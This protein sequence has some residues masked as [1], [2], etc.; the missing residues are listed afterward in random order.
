[1]SEA[2]KIAYDWFERIIDPCDAQNSWYAEEPPIRR[3][4]VAATVKRQSSSCMLSQ[5]RV[6]YALHMAA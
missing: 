3:I 2:A 5:V 1:M 6:M 4:V